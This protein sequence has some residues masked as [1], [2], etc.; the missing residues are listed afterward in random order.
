[1]VA[2]FTGAFG[3][4]RRDSR[5]CKKENE[6]KWNPMGVKK[7]GAFGDRRRDSRFGKKKNEKKWNPMGVKKSK[8]LSSFVIL[9]TFFQEKMSFCRFR[10][11]LV[12]ILH[13][14]FTNGFCS[15]YAFIFNKF[16]NNLEEVLHFRSHLSI[17][18]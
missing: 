14:I 7:S 2:E 12:P 4:R 17:F 3:D 6:K 9:F 13:V 16:G 1:M 10:D 18:V 8:G 15:F 5:F 11:L